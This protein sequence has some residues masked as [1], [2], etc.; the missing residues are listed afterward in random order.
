MSAKTIHEVVDDVY[1]T[2]TDSKVGM[3]L[4]PSDV[5]HIISL[6]LEGLI[7]SDDNPNNKAVNEILQ[8]IADEC[9]TVS[10]E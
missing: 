10:D 2:V 9:E 6:F 3:D 1:A 8:V 5:G 4:S 7:H